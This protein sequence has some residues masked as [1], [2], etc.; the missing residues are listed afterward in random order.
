MAGRNQFPD[1][2]NHFLPHKIHDIRSIRRDSRL[3]P[4]GVRA[5]A[6]EGVGNWST[7]SAGACAACQ[8][9]LRLLR[10]ARNDNA[11]VFQRSLVIVLSRERFLLTK[12]I[13]TIKIIIKF[14]SHYLTTRPL[15]QFPTRL[16]DQTR[17]KQIDF[18]NHI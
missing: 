3:R 7:R 2:L 18:H 13:K 14:K 16:L 17:E 12:T 15:D 4:G 11:G 5:Y 10:V 1:T 8:H 9:V 6:P